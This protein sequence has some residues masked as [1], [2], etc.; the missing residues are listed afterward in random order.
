MEK[1]LNKDLKTPELNLD[2]VSDLQENIVQGNQERTPIM[3]HSPLS[4]VNTT[5]KFHELT[6]SNSNVTLQKQG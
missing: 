5:A 4:G 1:N 2:L 6:N 3:H